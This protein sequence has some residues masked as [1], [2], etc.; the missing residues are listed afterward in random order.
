MVLLKNYPQL[1]S[2]YNIMIS[3]VVFM[4]AKHCADF[5]PRNGKVSYILS[6]STRMPGFISL[7][8]RGYS[9]IVFVNVFINGQSLHY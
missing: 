7:K 8:K 3:H 5:R 4:V 1:I 6:K 9:L 2:V